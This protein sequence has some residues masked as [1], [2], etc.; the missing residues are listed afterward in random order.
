MLL[1]FAF[2]LTLIL[3]PGELF[4][5]VDELSPGIY[6]VVNEEY[7]PLDR[8]YGGTSN[9]DLSINGPQLGPAIVWYKGTTSSIEAADRFVYVL[10][11]TEKVRF[12]P[13]NKGM[14]PRDMKV[15]SL[16]VN[17][18]KQ[19]REY[20]V[21]GR[22]LVNRSGLD[23]DWKE[24]NDYAFEIHIPEIAPGEYGIVFRKEKLGLFDYVRI[25]CFTVPENRMD[26][27]EY[28]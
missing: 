6:A 3:I 13:F 20:S 15:L 9:R 1:I 16:K 7:I 11:P 8:V 5:Q 4:A 23:F 10:N 22:R 28:Q 17:K 2:V 19:Q 21:Y 14:T 26:H 24:L 18:E 27:R 25:Y 12:S